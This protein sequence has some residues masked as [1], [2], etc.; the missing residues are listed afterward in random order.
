[1]LLVVERAETKDRNDFL[2]PWVVD[3]IVDGV[4]VEESNI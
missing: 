4:V 1:M 2:W 3:S